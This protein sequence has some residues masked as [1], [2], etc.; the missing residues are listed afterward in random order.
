MPI[1]QLSDI[2]DQKRNARSVPDHDL[3]DLLQRAHKART[4]DEIGLMVF[5]DVAAPCVLV[6][7]R[8][9]VK[10]FMQGQP[11]AFQSVGI[12]GHLVLP[13]LSAPAID[14][15]HPGNTRQ[16]PLDDPVVDAPKLCS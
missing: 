6:V 2:A 1:T 15:D 14:L 16:L 13:Q 11:V 7:L 8:E 3:T 5:F 4:P 9:R 12:H 10:D